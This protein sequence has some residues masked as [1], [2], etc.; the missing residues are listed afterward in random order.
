MILEFKGWYSGDLGEE[1]YLW[2][3]ASTSR[4]S[5][6]NRTCIK[7]Y[8]INDMFHMMLEM[9]YIVLVIHVFKIYYLI[10]SKSVYE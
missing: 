10:V 2:N 6:T 3:Y 9:E 4:K 5:Y 7:P 8:T 1:S